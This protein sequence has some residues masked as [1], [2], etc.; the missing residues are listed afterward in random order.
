MLLQIP[1]VEQDLYSRI[2]NQRQNISKDVS[3]FKFNKKRIRVLS[4]AQEFPDNCDGVLY[5]MSRDQRVQGKK[6]NV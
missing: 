4:E 3:G 2:V 5:W 6:R 1:K